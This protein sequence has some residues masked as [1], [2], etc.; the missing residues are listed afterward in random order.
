[1]PR[2]TDIFLWHP[3]ELNPLPIAKKITAIMLD[4]GY[5][6]GYP[7]EGVANGYYANAQSGSY[8]LP[9]DAWDALRWF[10]DLDELADVAS[11]MEV[12]GMGFTSPTG[13]VV[14]FGWSSFSGIDRPLEPHHR[15][16]WGGG[17]SGIDLAL[18]WASE[19]TRSGNINDRNYYSMEEVL[20]AYNLI[21]KIFLDVGFQF[22][23]AHSE[24]QY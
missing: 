20:T 21:K 15:K 24:D 18:C 8:R 2:G 16:K 6:R 12:F 23:C 13:R 9:G 10:T 11:E 19:C 5:E 4:W 3:D 17:F 7:K 22:A 1:M 14:G